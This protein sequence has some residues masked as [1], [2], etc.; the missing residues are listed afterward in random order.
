MIEVQDASDHVRVSVKD[1]GPGIPRDEQHKIF[2]RFAD[3]ANSDRASK[4][5]TGLGLNICKGIIENLGGTI[6]F[7]TEEGVGSTFY[8][9]LPKAPAK[10][11]VI[12]NTAEKRA[13]A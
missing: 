3:M 9:T 12:N 4:G 6:G 10:D 7:E 8:F 13:A 5:G 1:E 2:D 11:V